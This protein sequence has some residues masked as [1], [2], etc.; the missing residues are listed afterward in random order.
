MGYGV[1]LVRTGIYI[2]GIGRRIYSSAGC[3]IIFHT[4][5]T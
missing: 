5:Y 4:A 1:I 3:G 2:L